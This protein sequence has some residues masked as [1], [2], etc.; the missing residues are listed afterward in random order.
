[1][2]NKALNIAQIV[3]LSVISAVLVWMF[4]IKPLIP[5]RVGYDPRSRYS[6]TVVN[7]ADER[8]NAMYSIRGW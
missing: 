1:M 6:S 8:S 5:S 4:I 2:S 3:L 7:A